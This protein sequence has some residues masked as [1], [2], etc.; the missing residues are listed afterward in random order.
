MIESGR[1]TQWKK[2]PMIY[3]LKGY[4]KLAVEYSETGTFE[5]SQRYAAK[6]EEEKTAISDILNE[7][8]GNST[9]VPNAKKD[10]EADLNHFYRVEF[11]EGSESIRNFEGEIVSQPLIEEIK[12]LCGSANNFFQRI[13]LNFLKQNMESPFLPQR[14]LLYWHR[15]L[16]NT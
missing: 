12:R 2:N 11:N 15:S 1:L 14:S 13:F 16:K 5:P 6:T 7:L 4:R 10:Q 3:F 9:E 8:T